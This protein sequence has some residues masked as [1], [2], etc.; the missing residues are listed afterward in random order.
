[1]RTPK[2]H[3][4]TEPCPSWCD[5]D[6]TGQE[7]VVDRRHQTELAALPAIVRHCDQSNSDQEQ[8]ETAVAEEVIV[9]MHRRV[10]GGETWV[11]IAAERQGIEI[12][13]ETANRIATVLRSTLPSLTQDGTRP[14]T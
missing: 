11:A 5:G 8:H 6:H 10:G 1:M 13:V 7:H 4:L 2:P 12:S 14:L 9:V 3:W